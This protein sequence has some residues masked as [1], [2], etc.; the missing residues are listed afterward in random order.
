LT[1]ILILTAVAAECE[2]VE[3][4]LPESARGTVEVIAG[5]VGAAATAVSAAAALAA[6]PRRF[7]V[8]AG[9]GGA[10]PGAAEIGGLLLAGRI[11]AAD[12]G[13]E[14]QD[15]FLSLDELGFGATVFEA[16]PVPGLEAVFGDLLTVNTTTGTADRCAKLRA[17]HPKAVGEAME[18]YGVA[19]A[20]TRF[21]IPFA[22]VRAVSNVIGPRDRSAW[23]I[24]DALA[25]LARAAPQIV[26]GLSP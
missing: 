24:G 17:A 21:G 6:R 12:L 5:G 19:V 2:A 3:R 7:V 10:F 8:S 11:I 15:G 26:E 9:I 4:G 16:A 1:D 18:G 14:T 22:E 23:R 25:A 13:A 20:A